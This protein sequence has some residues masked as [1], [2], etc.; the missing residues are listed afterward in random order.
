MLR[1]SR[2]V[3][4]APQ[5]NLCGMSLDHGWVGWV[6]GRIHMA[7]YKHMYAYIGIYSQI[8]GPRT[9]YVMQ[10]AGGGG[11]LVGWRLRSQYQEGIVD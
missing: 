7:T 11:G 2:G 6:V 10:K 9:K 1:K 4:F 8:F 5:K 3:F